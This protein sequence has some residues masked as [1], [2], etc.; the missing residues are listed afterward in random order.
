MKH[1]RRI[2]QLEGGLRTQRRAL[3][4]LIVLVAVLLGRE[5][6][7]PIW[8][9]TSV[10]PVPIVDR[11]RVREIE[12][13]APD[14]LPSIELGS[15]AF[16][17]GEI[18]IRGYDNEISLVEAVVLSGVGISFHSKIIDDEIDMSRILLTVGADEN[19]GIVSVYNTEEKLSARLATAPEGDGRLV[20]AD[21][22]GLAR[23]EALAGAA[24]RIRLTDSA[25]RHA[26]LP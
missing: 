5:L 14:G 2:Q 26:L 7:Q 15:S 20:V 18:I 25:G 11:L 22:G 17:S 4:L 9:Q 12:I 21:R 23:I 24:G 16:N 19:G 10:D 3:S 1:D 8:A 6:I 13:V